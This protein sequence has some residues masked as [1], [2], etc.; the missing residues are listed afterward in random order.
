MII[1]L[2]LKGQCKIGY[3]FSTLSRYAAGIGL[4]LLDRLFLVT[5]AMDWHGIFWEDFRSHMK[6]YESI[7]SADF[8]QVTECGLVMLALASIHFD[9]RWPFLFEIAEG[10]NILKM[11][12]TLDFREF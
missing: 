5:A 8:L 9:P 7:Q 12:K 4:S 11:V 10:G 3:I 1:L 2:H 6:P